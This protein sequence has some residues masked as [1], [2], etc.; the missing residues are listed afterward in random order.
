MFCFITQ[1][2]GYWYGFNYTITLTSNDISSP[3][4]G[5]LTSHNQGHLKNIE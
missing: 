5:Y 3:I 1:M 2:F 4:M